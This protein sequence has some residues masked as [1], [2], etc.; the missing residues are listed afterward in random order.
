MS[1]G[2]SE[3]ADVVQQLLEICHDMRQPVASVCALA[4]ALAEPDLPATAG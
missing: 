2:V 3:D 1:I 4:A